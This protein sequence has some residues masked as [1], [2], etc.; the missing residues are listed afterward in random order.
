MQNHLKKTFLL[1]VCTVAFNCTLLSQYSNHVFTDTA[2]FSKHTISDSDFHKAIF[3]NF[4]NF[5]VTKFSNRANFN[6]ATFS[7]Y[8]DFRSAVFSKDANFLGATFSKDA[9]FYGVTFNSVANFHWTIIR[10]NL[11]FPYT[12]F[13]KK[14][15][16]AYLKVD[17]GKFL[18]IHAQLPDS[19]DLSYN[20]AIQF[21]IDLT[22]SNLDS[23]RPPDRCVLARYFKPYLPYD[24]KTD[25]NHYIFINLLNT[26][27][28]K[29]KIDY[30]HFRL[31]LTDTRASEDKA[32]FKKH[33]DLL[34]HDQKASIYQSLL[35]NFQTSGQTESY[36]NLEIEY[37]YLA[38]DGSFLSFWLPDW[39]WRFGHEKWRVFLHIV[40]FL[41]LFTI[42]TFFC[43]PALN[44]RVY[45]F[46]FIPEF[47]PLHK[48][49]QL[50]LESGFIFFWNKYY[51]VKKWLHV[52]IHQILAR[53]WYS[54]V[55]ST[56]IF[57]VIYLKV[58]KV[59][60]SRKLG[61][62]YLM[63]VYSTGLICLGYIAN[64]IIA[65]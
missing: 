34:S 40:L 14:L 23:I 62:F 18:F 16:L 11:F 64:Y 32:W 3:S 15:D 60:F 37:K 2:N 6:M 56:I 26:D 57:F 59:Q 44:N 58:E 36:K 61:T 50:T 10:T 21:G 41:L 4:A 43:L 35:K 54:F 33:S 46:E 27:I 49:G 7:N 53:F 12:V 24:K 8:A 39:W 65:K 1:L 52:F 17:S 25:T 51:P 38:D 42:I 31:W 19:I 9:N 22:V 30:I 48:L 55:Y 13:K 28:S 47:H 29:V 20:P 45:N 5:W 63:I